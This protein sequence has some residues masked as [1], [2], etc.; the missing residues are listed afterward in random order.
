M[1]EVR[2][3]DQNHI[4]RRQIAKVHPGLA[5]P[6]KHKQPAGEVGIEQNILSAHLQKE[7]GMT[8]K[9]QTQ[10]AVA[11]EFWF[12][13]LAGAGCNGG[14]AHQAAKLPGPL[15][16]YRIPQ[17]GIYDR[18]LI[19]GALIPISWILAFHAYGRVSESLPS[20]FQSFLGR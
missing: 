9:S 1:V 7:A 13:G 10:L 15:A 2:V 19:F 12:V 20:G 6:L 11:H 4:N 14:V 5:Q 18:L 17:R 16:E 3:R 8:D